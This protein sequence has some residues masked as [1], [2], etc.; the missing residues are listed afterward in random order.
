M[1][2]VNRILQ[3]AVNDISV[4]SAVSKYLHIDTALGFLL[5]TDN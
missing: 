4:A 1:Y 5:L 3:Q 2:C